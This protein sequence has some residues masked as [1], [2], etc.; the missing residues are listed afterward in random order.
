VNGSWAYAPIG[1]TATRT[2]TFYHRDGLS[3]TLTASKGTILPAGPSPGGNWSWS[4]TSAIGDPASV[5]YVY[6]TVTDSAA[7]KDQAVFRLQ[8]GGTDAGSDVGDP[9]IR[10]VDG[11]RYDFQAAGEFT[12]LRD[13][14]GMEI[15][16]RQTPAET[17]PPVPDDYTG[18]TECVS[19]NTAVAARVGSHRISY[20]PGREPG[21]LQFFLDGKPAQFPT[22]EGLDLDGHRVTTF[23]AGGETAL[24]VDYAHGPVFT[25]TPRFWTSYGL[26]YLDESVSNTNGDEGLMGR[27]HKGTWLPNLPNGATAALCLRACTRVMSRSTRPSPTHG[28]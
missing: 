12:L 1:G 24:R 21:R 20:Q 8:I 16:V 22:R 19:L 27:I 13:R 6:I 5:E 7:R 3:M 10:T 14:E 2:G 9:H 17:P 15:Q 18:L 4:Y 28:A 23:A 11:K 25:A 26:W